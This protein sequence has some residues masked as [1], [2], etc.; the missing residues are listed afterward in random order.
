MW[1]CPRCQAENRESSAA[2]ASCG[3]IRSAGRFTSSVQEPRVVQASRV[4]APLPESS[5]RP[6]SIRNAY[7]PPDPEM[8]RK[9]RRHSHPLLTLGKWTGTGLCILL[10]IL[11]AL[12]AWRQYDA[13]AQALLPLLIP[14]DA[15]R[16]IQILLYIA[17]ALI[18][19]LLS[20]LP[21]LWTLLLARQN[22]PKERGG[23]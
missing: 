11:T 6:A 12:L 2:C 15:P 18:A 21:G 13:L 17:L 7:Q 23:R 19:V 4:S 9:S 20:M 3:A 1:I 5:Q 22:S 10:P 14:G 8:G 16:A